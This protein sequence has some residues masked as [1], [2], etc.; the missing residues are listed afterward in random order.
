MA[1]GI[2]SGIELRRADVAGVSAPAMGS[3]PPTRVVISGSNETR[4]HT[5]QTQSA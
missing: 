5:S 4:P 3:M 1:G 2:E